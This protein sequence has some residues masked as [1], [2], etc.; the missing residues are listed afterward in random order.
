VLRAARVVVHLY[1]SITWI[2]AVSHKHT[3]KAHCFFFLDFFVVIERR[4]VAGSM[5]NSDKDKA[6]FVFARFF[7]RGR[8]RFLN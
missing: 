3:R 4:G 2:R 6:A 7:G 5:D 1:L 8:G